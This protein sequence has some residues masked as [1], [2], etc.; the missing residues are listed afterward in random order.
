MKPEHLWAGTENHNLSDIKA[1]MLYTYCRKYVI[2]FSKGSVIMLVS[3]K[4]ELE[5][6][7]SDYR[8][9]QGVPSIEVTKNGRIFIAFYSGGTKEEM[10]NFVVLKKSEDGVNFSQP[11]AAA[12][13]DEGYRCYDQCLWIDPLGRLWFMWSKMPDHAVHAAICDDPDAD[14]LKWGE[15][16]EVGND[17]MMN[18][19]TVLSTGEWL[20]PI[21]VW[22]KNVISGCIPQTKTKDRK[23]FVYKTVDNGK[24]FTKMGGASVPHRAFDEHMVLELNDGI[25]AMYV[26]TS[27]GIGVSYSY[28]R[29]KTWTGGGDSGISGPCSRFHIRRLKSGRVLLLNHVNFTE[30]NDYGRNNLT[31]LLSE[32]DGKTWKYSLLLDGRDSVSYPDAKEADDGYIYITYDRDRGGLKN[33]LEEV[34]ACEREILM[35]KITEDDIINGKL[36]SSESKLMVVADKLGKYSKENENPYKEVKKY[37][38]KELAEC[39][40]EKTP[41]EIKDILFTHYRLN[42]ECM[43]R[44]MYTQFDNLME[45]L[46]NGEGNRKNLILEIIR[47]IRSVVC[48]KKQSMPII[49]KIKLVVMENLDKDMSIKELSEKVGLSNYYM[50]HLFKNTTGITVSEFRNAMRLTKAKEMLINSDDKIADIAYTCGFGSSSYFSKRFISSEKISPSEYRERFKK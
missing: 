12:I 20:F 36:V 43:G 10:G 41:E 45:K 47:L 49:E 8:L 39:L 34:Y 46:E 26:R 18:R 17:I 22:A 3:N 42:C 19:P 25:L 30:R 9:W 16:F 11:I 21:A 15:E 35:A 24:T 38:E 31:A 33:S 6:Y 27:Y 29:G 32:D 14:E 1:I 13:P 44:M 37:S 2:M 40:E 7:S 28:D 4:K 5:K 48:V 23:A 50:A